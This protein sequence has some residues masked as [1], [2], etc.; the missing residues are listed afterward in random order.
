MN[1]AHSM[2]LIAVIAAVTLILRFLPFVIFSGKREV[3]KY[4][5]FLGDRLPYAIMGMLIVYCLRN[6]SFAAVSDWLP[7]FLSIIVVVILHVWRRNTLLSII[8]GTFVYMF[9]IQAVL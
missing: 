8:G 9:L 3:P 2:A 7:S 4:I 5:L 1:D 6:V